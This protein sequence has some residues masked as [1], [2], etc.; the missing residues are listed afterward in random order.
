[1]LSVQFCVLIFMPYAHLKSMCHVGYLFVFVVRFV[2]C[3]PLPPPPPED[4]VKVQFE[5]T[6]KS[7]NVLSYNT[8]KVLFFKFVFYFELYSTYLIEATIINLL[9]MVADC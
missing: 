4:F 2:H 6:L 3:F 9:R 5:A 7:F 1:M 8:H